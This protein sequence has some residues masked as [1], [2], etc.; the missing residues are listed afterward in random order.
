MAREKAKLSERE[1][2]VL[3]LVATGATNQQIAR[4]LYISVNT[5]KVHLRN[6]F[7]KLEVESRTEAVLYAVRQGWITVEG[8]TAPPLKEE[9][10]AL[11]RI[12][13]P[14]RAFFLL[15]AALVLAGLFLSRPATG[16]APSPPPSEFADHSG[17]IMEASLPGLEVSRWKR[18]AQMP[19]PRGRL[20]VVSYRNLIYAIAGDSPDGV[21]GVVEVYDP[22]NDT[23]DRRANKPTPVSNVGAA[24][25]GDLIY[26]PGGYTAEGQVTSVLEVYDPL[27]DTWEEKAPLP[28]PLCAYAIAALDDELYI[29]GGWDGHRYVASTYKYDPLSDS[30]TE[31]SPLTMPRGFAAAGAI[32][33][34]IYLVGGYNGQQELDLLEEYDP[35]LEKEGLNPWTTKAPMSLGRGG[36]GVA[37]VGG[38]LY[39][40]GG[41]WTGYL[42]FNERYDPRTD[43]WSR[44][45]T[46]LAGCWRNLGVAGTETK[47]YAIGGWSGQY[48]SLNEEYQ[49]LFRLLLP[50]SP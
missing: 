7:D 37:V 16:E 29:F 14:E 9:T 43:T 40:I 24:V 22:G 45:E 48:L 44:F 6:I 38:S 12:S 49:A 28:R 30:W 35:S 11:R 36:A 27:N 20:A 47:A 50:I 4:Q 42:A 34:R 46:P 18:R 25:I 15:A 8:A 1:L 5:V 31:M 39:V 21:T 23:W 41:G 3:R 17:A 19:T 32:K 33:G 2:E 10:K 26:V 13:L